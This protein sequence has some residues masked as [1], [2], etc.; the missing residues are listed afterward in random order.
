MKNSR[1]GAAVVLIV[2]VAAALMFSIPLIAMSEKTY[3]SARESV[4]ASTEKLKNKIIRTAEFTIED[5][6]GFI[7]EIEATGNTFDVEIQLDRIGANASKKVSKA[8]G[9]VQS[10]DNYT[11]EYTTQILD[12]LKKEG[13]IKL[14]PGSKVSIAAVATNTPISQIFNGRA[15]KIDVLSSGVVGK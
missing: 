9:T 3:D 11:T 7:K 1:G 5:Y 6:D 13:T 14:E 12:Q 2:I 15:D 4:A 8:D 10:T